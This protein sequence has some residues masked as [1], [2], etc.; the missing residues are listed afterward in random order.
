MFD[1]SWGEVFVVGAVGAALAGRRDLP[2]ACRF[3]GTQVGRVVGILQGARARADRFTANNELRQLQNELRSGLRELDQ[4]K[5]EM[6]V[7]A[8]MGR[9]LGATTASA[10]RLRTPSGGATRTHPTAGPA[11]TNRTPLTS[12]ETRYDTTQSLKPE[13]AAEA[14]KNSNSELFPTVSA[15]VEIPNEDSMPTPPAIQSERATIEEEWEKQGIGFRSRA[16]QGLWMAE[17]GTSSS[18]IGEA[19]TGSEL[20]GNL[21]KENLIFDQYDRVVGDQENEMQNRIEQIKQ[22]REGGRRKAD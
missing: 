1:I 18:G 10:N 9:T 13:V 16:E 6:A 3:I 14:L 8:S 11:S 20:L 21:I 22:R 7:A 17:S 4:V 15:D 19:R 5:M 2:T 12:T